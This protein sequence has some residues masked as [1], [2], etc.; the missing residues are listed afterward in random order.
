MSLDCGL[1]TVD[2]GLVTIN[3]FVLVW[4]AVVISLVGKE[5]LV[6]WWMTDELLC[7]GQRKAAILPSTAY[8]AQTM[9]MPCICNKC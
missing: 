8:H 4:Y 2:S 7:N 3:N 1:W 9:P 6:N 5:K